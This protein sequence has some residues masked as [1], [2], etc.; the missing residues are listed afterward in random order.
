MDNYKDSQ[1]INGTWG[2]MWLSGDKMSECT[3]LQAKVALKKTAVN[4]CGTLVDGQKVT[5]IECK[6]TLKLNKVTSKMIKLLSDS[7]KKGL[8]P[9]FT[10]ISKLADPGALGTERIVLKGVTFDELTLIDW[11]AKKNGEESIPFTFLD[12]E[13]LDLI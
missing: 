13:P 2:E 12:W 10:I 5:G 4:M 6:G 8:M 11:E 1:V 3:S 7:I 9:E